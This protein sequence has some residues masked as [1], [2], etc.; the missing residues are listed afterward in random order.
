MKDST[1]LFSTL[2]K[3]WAGEAN[4]TWDDLH[5]VFRAGLV[6][7]PPGTG[8]PELTPNGRR[9]F[10]RYELARARLLY[11]NGMPY[12]TID[13][14]LL[15]EIMEL[16]F[17]KPEEGYLLIDSMKSSERLFGPV[18]EVAAEEV[19]E[20]IPH[21]RDAALEMTRIGMKEAPTDWGESP[22]KSFGAKFFR[23][24]KASEDPLADIADGLADGSLE[25]TSHSFEPGEGSTLKTDPIKVGIYED[26][27]VHTYRPVSSHECKKESIV[28]NSSE[29]R[30]KLV[31][32]ILGDWKCVYP[33]QKPTQM[34]SLDIGAGMLICVLQW[35]SGG[36]WSG[37]V[38]F[39]NSQIRSHRSSDRFDE[40]HEAARH[41]I[42]LARATITPEADVLGG[43]EYT[44][45]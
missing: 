14:G 4:P 43:L 39:D 7:A 11:G 6:K 16:P 33:R 12:E 23:K 15:P 40:P 38:D 10:A 44:D 37:F 31:D 1:K 32:F 28:V 29:V 36:Q 34:W 22:L 25:I 20:R 5:A 2:S 41:A 8:K 3:V 17:V 27:L 26:A 30:A 18:A 13:E 19:I 24:L 21:M 9:K 45:L 42:E 35:E